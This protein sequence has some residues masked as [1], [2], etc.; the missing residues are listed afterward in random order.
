MVEKKWLH[1]LLAFSCRRACM[2]G[3]PKLIL[4]LPPAAVSILFQGEQK[5]RIE[6]HSRI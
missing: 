3:N 6:C 2:D 1:P 5:K 4:F